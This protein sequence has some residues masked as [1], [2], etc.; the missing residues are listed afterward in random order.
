MNDD[1]TAA[2]VES[3]TKEIVNVFVEKCGDEGVLFP[4]LS[5]LLSKM[6]A[7]SLNPKEFK[8][9]LADFE[10]AYRELRK[11]NNHLKRPTIN[12]S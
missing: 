4:T 7:R 1:E 2:R 6:C 3:L 5:L 12:E 9:F 10:N 8:G 11:E